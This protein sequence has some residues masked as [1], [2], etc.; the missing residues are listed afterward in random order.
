MDLSY[1]NFRSLIKILSKEIRPLKT[2]GEVHTE[3]EINDIINLLNRMRFNPNEYNSYVKYSEATYTRSLVGFDVD[4]NNQSV[5]TVLLLCWAPGQYSPI[6]DHS[7]SSCFVKVLKGKVREVRYETDE[8]TKLLNVQSDNV[9]KEEQA[10]FINDTM[11]FHEMGNPSNDEIAVTLHVYCPPYMMCRI[12]CKEKRADEFEMGSMQVVETQKNPTRSHTPSKRVPKLADYGSDNKRQNTQ[13]SL[14]EFLLDLKNVFSNPDSDMNK[15]VEILLK[16]LHLK[17]NEWKELCHFDLHRYSRSLMALD[18]EYSMMLLC[19]NCKQATPIHSHEKKTSTYVRILSGELTLKKFAD[20]ND[21]LTSATTYRE[22]DVINT[23]EFMGK[24]QLI[25]QNPNKPAVSI[26]VYNPPLVSMAYRDPINLKE[27]TIPIVH[28]VHSKIAETCGSDAL[29]ELYGGKIFVNTDEFVKEI[30]LN[31]DFEDEEKL[32][33]RI[34]D[35]LKRAEFNLK[36]LSQHL[37]TKK[38]VV[39]KKSDKFVITLHNKHFV[40]SKLNG[41]IKVING[42]LN[43]QILNSKNRIQSMVDLEKP[44]AFY[45]ETGQNV[46]YST[47]SCTLDNQLMILRVERL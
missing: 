21:E 6:H 32:V 44:N 8:K 11:G 33:D 37:G 1:T 46:K 14:D 2:K 47:P 10:T 42:R 19:W 31:F 34:Y 41:W 15:I 25:N 36:E 38:E 3:N 43:L 28:T 24:H 4:E 27:V 40:E 22:G 30:S 13:L 35:I 12:F 16:R 29:F 5:F 23:L 26:H 45:T 20:N 18:K 39:L 17:D 7:G 9:Y